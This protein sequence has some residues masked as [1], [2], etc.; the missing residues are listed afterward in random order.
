MMERPTTRTKIMMVKLAASCGLSMSNILATAEASEVEVALRPFTVC[1]DAPNIAYCRQNFDGGKFSFQQVGLVVSAL[2]AR[3]EEP[4]V[5]LPAKY[6]RKRVPNHV[7]FVKKKKAPVKRPLSPKGKERSEV[8]T[9]ED[10]ALIDSWMAEGRLF[11][12]PW[13]AND[14][15]FWIFATVFDRSPPPLGNAEGALGAAPAAAPPGPAF[16]G[17]SPN[18]SSPSAVLTSVA[19][20]SEASASPEAAMAPLAVVTNDQMRD[21]WRGLVDP[22]AFARWKQTAMLRFMILGQGEDPAPDFWQLEKKNSDEVGDDG[23]GGSAESGGEDKRSARDFGP[24]WG[25]AGKALSEPPNGG[26]PREAF[27]AAAADVAPRPVFSPIAQITRGERGGFRFLRPG[28]GRS[29]SEPRSWHLPTMEGKW[30]CIEL[31]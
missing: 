4:L 10:R 5:L 12:T 22:V 7:R 6:S 17:V 14:D 13:G 21:H 16:A 29:A 26:A 28:Q 18:S 30:L 9:E 19:L 31:D 15:W 24:G 27:V 1:L 11:V 2:K 25:E 20:T 23:G 8:V 3:G